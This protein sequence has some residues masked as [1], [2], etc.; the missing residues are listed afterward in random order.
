MERIFDSLAKLHF[1]L[2]GKKDLSPLEQQ[3]VS[4]WRASLNE[5]ERAVLDAQLSAVQ[6]IQR[7][8]G[9]ARLVFYYR[10]K[11]DAIPLF[12]NRK[13]DLHAAD[14]FVGQPGAPAERTMR[15]KVFLNRGSFAA[16]EY[17]K[18]P[19]RYMELHKM[20]GDNLQVLRVEQ[21]ASVS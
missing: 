17:P 2:F 6:M 9:G 13:P 14:V 20:A 1:R 19:S 4:A 15:M 16:V 11:G 18:R 3:S 21:T 12:A 7:Q 8:A 5:R 10:D